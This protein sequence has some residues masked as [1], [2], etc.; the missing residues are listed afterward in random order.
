[1]SQSKVQHSKFPGTQIVSL[2]KDNISYMAKFQYMV[3]PKLDGIRYFLLTYNG[4]VFLVDRRMNI[5]QLSLF[6][7]LP[8][9]FNNY[10]LDGELINGVTDNKKG[11]MLRFVV[12]DSLS[13]NGKPV[14][15]M[16]SLSERLHSAHKLVEF[17]NRQ[18]SDKPAQK[19][20]ATSNQP[21]NIFDV[22]NAEEEEKVVVEKKPVVPAAPKVAFTFTF[23]NFQLIHKTK[24][25]LE[26]ESDMP[27]KTDGVVFMPGHMFYKLGYNRYAMKWKPDEQNTID[28]VVEKE[29]LEDGSSEYQLKV[30]GNDGKNVKYDVLH[31]LPVTLKEGQEPT[32]FDN[33]TPE[34][35]V[36]LNGKIV[37][38][39]WDPEMELPQS[40]QA[41]VEEK[42][43][44]A[45]TPREEG[46]EKPEGEEKEKRQHRGGWRISKVR[47]DKETP[48]AQWV[49]EAM[50]NC[51]K[52]PISK[53][54]L[55]TFITEKASTYK[56]PHHRSKGR[57]NTSQELRAPGSANKAD[58][59]RNWRQRSGETAEGEGSAEP[60]STPSKLAPGSTPANS[61]PTTP[62]KTPSDKPKGSPWRT[63]GTPATPS[64]PSSSGSSVPTT[65]SKS[66]DEDDDFIDPHKGKRDK[67]GPSRGG[68]GGG[69]QRGR[70]RGGK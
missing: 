27:Y 29:T 22:L 60:P 18:L 12:F 20:K 25:V 17:L 55:L 69:A 67:K 5:V 53:E 19:E 48:N 28:F 32:E 1:L 6:E 36:E 38:C 39:R 41:K 21:K 70:G 68:R 14:V 24:E 43:A 45:V 63:M 61:N 8:A 42:P 40:A 13:I 10:L 37:E 50:I 26:S 15:T 49:V 9:Q 66:V 51:V 34:K 7:K 16:E 23:Q 58:D 2:Y 54:E 47:T 33:L 44:E 46:E 56:S 59:D 4:G 52:A 57:I 65:P 31:L 64:T 3:A 30:L 11:P 62:A 35:L